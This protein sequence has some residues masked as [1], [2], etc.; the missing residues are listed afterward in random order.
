[1]KISN[2]EQLIGVKLVTKN[3]LYAKVE[4]E[5]KQPVVNIYT[6]EDALDPIVVI[7]WMSTLKDGVDMLRKFGFDVEYKEKFNLV[8]FLKENL[9]PK[10]FNFNERNFYFA[11]TEYSNIGVICDDGVKALNC[12]YFNSI[13]DACYIGKVLRNESVTIGWLNLTLKELG[14]L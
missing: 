12:K 8:N 13:N 10:E 9:E 11:I 3:K 14:W 2:W 4:K 6:A 7:D 1:M 5:N